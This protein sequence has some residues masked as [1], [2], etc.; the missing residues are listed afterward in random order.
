MSLTRFF[1]RRRW[2]D[3]RARELEA[4]LAHEIDDNIARG[5]T[6]GEA[7]TAAHRKL[8]NP[9]RIREEIYTMNSI[10]FI[11]TLWQ[12]LRYGARLLRRNP[13]FAV[14]AILTL[15]LGTGANT[16]IFQ[17]VDAV[18]LRTLPVDRPEELAEVRIVKAPNGRTGNFM[19]RWPRLTYPLY[20]KIKEQQQVFSDLVAWGSMSLDLSQGGEQRPAQALWVSGNFFSVLGVRP[21]AGRLLAPSDDVRGCAPG[22]VLGHP[23][24]QREYGGDPSVVGRTILLDGQRFDIVGV[25][26]AE[27]YG[28][29]VGRTFDLALPICAEPVIRGTN[30]ALEKPDVWFLAGLGRLKPGVTVEQAG[31]HL[32][33]LSKG[34]LSATVSERYTAA[35]AKDY[36]E[37]VIGASGASGGLSGLRS[38]YGASLNILLA[39]TGL[40]LLIACANLANLMLARATARER[41]VAVRLAI[42]ASRRRIVRQM[43]SESLLIAAIGAAGGV[44]VAQWFSRSLVAFL[45]TADNPRFVDLPMDWRVFAF[46]AAVAVAA[47]LIF[48]LT[49]AIRATRASLG[50]TMKTGSRGMTDGRERFGIRRALVVLQVAVSLVLVVGA[51]L[52]VR[53]LRNLTTMDP[54]FRQEGVL[55]ASLDTRKANVPTQSRAAMTARLL[56]RVRAIPGVVAAA[57]T[58]TTPLSGN[59]WNNQI[60][61]GG[62][63]QKEMVNFNSV[64][65]GYFETL[66]VRL[67]VGRDFDARD[68]PQSPKVAIVTESFV[69][70]YFAG[71][72]PVGQSFQIEEPAGEPRPSYQIVGVVRDTKYSDLRE[73]F[74][75]LAHLAAQQDAAPGPFLRIAI[76][77]ETTPAAVTAAVTRAVAEVNPAIAIQYQTVKTQVEQSLLRERLMATL[78]GFFGGL[79]VL[80]ATIGLYGVMSYMVARR[81]TEIGVRMA[82]G[83]DH[84]MVVR[85]IVRE[86]GV[87]LAIGLGIG[88][89]LSVYAARTA[90]TF[91]YELTPSDPVTLAIAIAGLATVTLLA[92]WIPARR[93]ARLQP[94]VALRDE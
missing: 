48:G 19:G 51:L 47:C 16:A 55:T 89:L 36:V 35:D 6:P 5:M 41:E 64:G 93:A 23:F 60:V 94:T 25:T 37:M 43:L 90:A 22:V 76:R 50:S 57:Q 11:E 31:A 79:A 68:T 42:G 7:R 85:M 77:A 59:S 38:D 4:H 21:A 74:T 54:G 34:I 9:T 92:S 56:E 75:P 81:R 27:F 61:V 32:A 71:R 33:G 84:G 12:D 24:W 18:R 13:T 49:P 28:V 52:F 69:R 46:T 30:T 86:A 40:V 17:L 14:V 83:A 91:L 26:S 10:A 8:G 58:Y 62:A 70:K 73:P 39:V 82:L 87:L 3:E 80:I 67:V 66:G 20:L 44:L 45:G 15:A 65:P 88:A 1:R 2:D 63:G 78:S 53:S 72:D 29:D